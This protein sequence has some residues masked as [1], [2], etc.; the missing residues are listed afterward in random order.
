MPPPRKNDF[1]RSEGDRIDL[2][3][4]GLTWAQLSGSIDV[5]SGDSTIDIGEALGGAADSHT[6]AV[7]FVTDL[8]EVDF[9]FA[10]SSTS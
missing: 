3:A 9:L 1:D 6:V 2:T 8:V 5:A 7:R 10:R 4:T